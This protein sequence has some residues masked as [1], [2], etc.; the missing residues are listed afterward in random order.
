MTIERFEELLQQ[1]REKRERLDAEISSLESRIKKLEDEMISAAAD[2]QEDVFKAKKAEKESLSDS[3][4]VKRSFKEKM[5]DSVTADDAREAWA[6]F[7]KG[8]NK[9]MRAAIQ[10]FESEKAKLMQM[11]SDLIDMQKHAC[12]IREKLSDAAGAPV[13]SFDMETVPFQKGPQPTPMLRL[14][15]VSD[16]TDPDALYFLNDYAKKKNLYVF[17]GPELDPEYARVRSVLFH[18]KSKLLAK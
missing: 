5:K 4:Y 10:A 11:Y 16:L 8:H 14:G 13:E 1:D 15:G 17:G 7:T 6:D 18:Q 3:I 12:A 9:K 2:G